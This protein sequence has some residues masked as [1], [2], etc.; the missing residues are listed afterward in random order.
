MAC[1]ASVLVREVIA[2]GHAI[3]SFTGIHAEVI[4]APE[5]LGRITGATLFVWAIR[6]VAVEVAT[7]VPAAVDAGAVAALELAVE[8][9]HLHDE[10]YV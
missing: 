2:V 10:K 9:A 6:A 3:T 8:V 5:V 7:D 1:W 4:A